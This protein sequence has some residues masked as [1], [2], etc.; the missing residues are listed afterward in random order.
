MEH[1][2]NDMI[3]IHYGNKKF[4]IEHFY[5]VTNTNNTKPKFGL[6]GCPVS[7]FYF[8]LVNVPVVKSGLW[9]WV[10]NPCLL[11]SRGYKDCKLIKGRLKLPLFC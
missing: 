6:W 9:M 11:E 7:P 3:F 1:K 4:D 2:I 5:D 8:T 10:H